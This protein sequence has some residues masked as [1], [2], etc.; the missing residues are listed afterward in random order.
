MRK[1]LVLIILVMLCV[2]IVPVS[3]QDIAPLEDHTLYQMMSLVPDNADMRTGIMSYQDF[4]A[5]ENAADWIPTYENLDAFLAG[6]GWRGF[7][8]RWLSTPMSL[9]RL[10]VFEE[11]MTEYMG[12]DIFSVDRTF[13]VSRPPINIDVWAGEFNVDAIIEAHLARDYTETTIND[14]PAM[15]GAVGCENGTQV[16]VRNG[17]M[18]N[19]FDTGLGRQIPFV[20]F[21]DYL[22]S[23]TA[24]TFLEQSVDTS[25]GD[26]DSLADA[27]DLRTL[28][29]TIINPDMY[30]G[31]LVQAQFY[32]VDEVRYE[33]DLN[34]PSTLSG[35][36][37][38][39]SELAEL[40]TDY[41]TLPIY[42]GMVIADRQ[43]GDTQVNIIALL[44]DDVADAELAVEILSRRLSTFTRNFL[45]AD[46]E[47]TVLELVEGA[48]LDEGYVYTSETT[49]LSVAVVSVSYPMPA[50]RADITDP[51]SPQSPAMMYK[52]VIEAIIQRS[53][54]PLWDVI[55][56]EE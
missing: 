31:D 4:R 52:F 9:Y 22:V 27:D 19:I 6:D 15:C 34:D 43:E 28:M 21:P 30:A 37:V 38:S 29:E 49:G 39:A 53:F 46:E 14:V 24:Y 8:S 25:L 1:L 3:A 10:P 35:I 36:P 55:L 33:V 16:D 11:G 17:N 51:E 47:P 7:T 56:G 5:V 40:F 23:S 45:P 50:G 42:N 48:S 20:M 44:Y 12:F 2:T 26:P 54:T 18:P 13:S 32:P 41:G